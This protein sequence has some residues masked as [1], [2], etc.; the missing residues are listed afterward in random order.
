MSALHYHRYWLLIIVL[1]SL[2]IM[3]C[4]GDTLVFT[5]PQPSN[6]KTIDNIPEGFRGKWKIQDELTGYFVIDSRQVILFEKKEEA[7]PLD[8]LSDYHYFLKGDSLFQFSYTSVSKASASCNSSWLWLDEFTASVDTALL[9]NAEKVIVSVNNAFYQV[10]MK[11]LKGY[12]VHFDTVQQQYIPFTKAEGTSVHD[13]LFWYEEF[14]VGRIGD[15]TTTQTKGDDWVFL[16]DENDKLSHIIDHDSASLTLEDDILYMKKW[17]YRSLL[18]L[19]SN[20]SQIRKKK[21]YL[22]LNIEDVKGYWEPVI[23]EQINDNQIRYILSYF[24]D[25]TFIKEYFQVNPGPL[26][27]DPDSTNY[28]YANPSPKELFRLLQSDSLDWVDLVRIP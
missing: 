13:S 2:Q 4:E 26:P 3:A 28:Y 22:F 27:G 10:D 9:K 6:A 19:Y 21:Q 20:S 7:I 18:P 17:S 23:I 8:S 1:A 15:I 24:D 16:F 12:M 14:F 5:Q 25:I 11:E